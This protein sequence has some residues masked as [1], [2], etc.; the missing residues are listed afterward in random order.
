VTVRADK[1][2]GQIGLAALDSNVVGSVISYVP[3]NTVSCV[4]RYRR[5]Q[6]VYKPDSTGILPILQVIHLQGDVVNVYLDNFEIYAIP[7]GASVSG[8]M[9]GADGNGL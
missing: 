9:L 4:N 8:A 6:F 3:A 7:A 5:L 1:E 2:G